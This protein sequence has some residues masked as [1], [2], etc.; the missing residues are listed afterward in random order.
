VSVQK[1][2]K[3]TPFIKRLKLEE[4]CTCLDENHEELV[5]LWQLRQL[6]LSNGDLVSYSIR[7]REVRVPATA[8]GL[9]DCEDWR[10]FSSV[11]LAMLTSVQI[12]SF[13][14]A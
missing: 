2:S 12:C 9:A 10:E 5:D 3:R 8:V 14:H 4:I 6:S 13:L 7:K 11:A 1:T